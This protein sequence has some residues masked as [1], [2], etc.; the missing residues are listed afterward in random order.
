L[1]LFAL[2]LGVRTRYGL[3]SSCFIWIHKDSAEVGNSRE[4]VFCVISNSP[5]IKVR[6][7]L[8]SLYRVLSE[9]FSSALYSLDRK[10]L[11]I[12]ECFHGFLPMLIKKT[13]RFFFFFSLLKHHFTFWYNCLLIFRSLYKSCT[14]YQAVKKYFFFLKWYC[15]LR[16]I[17][18]VS[19]QS[20][21][22]YFLLIHSKN[23]SF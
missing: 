7:I 6:P 12:L 19:F 3:N 23:N 16:L 8:F 5:L 2:S 1:D 17:V 14:L 11:G 4:P 13:I 21:L 9:I 22:G 18:D 20:W 15:L 10:H